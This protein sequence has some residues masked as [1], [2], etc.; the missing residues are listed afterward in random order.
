LR[1]VDS[2]TVAS[3][4]SVRIQPPRGVPLF[5]RRVTILVQHLVDEGRYSAQLR[6]A[7]GRVMMPWRQRTAQR[8]AHNPPMHT[9]LRSH[10]RD[11]ADAKLML[12]TKLFE[13]IHFG[14][15]VHARSPD[16][17]GATLG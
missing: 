17:I 15:P 16:P 2:A 7:P 11:R 8:L 10:P 4:N 1:T 12:P 5:A 9:K 6:L 3:G 13:Q 14:S